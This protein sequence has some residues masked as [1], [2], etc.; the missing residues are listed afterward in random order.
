MPGLFLSHNS[1][2]KRFA[3]QLAAELS[4]NGVRVW[5]DEAEM[6]A[7]DS[8]L[9]KIGEGI[10]RADF[11]GVV[12]SPNSIASRW[13]QKEVEVAATM[14]IEGHGP[15]VIPILYKDCEIPVFL[16]D[17]LYADFRN[18]SM[19]QHSLMKLLDA[20]FPEGFQKRL[21]D[22][23][24]KAIAAEI[25]AYRRLPKIHTR[26]IDRYFTAS[27]SA[28]RRIVNL[29]HERQ[30]RKWVINNRLNPSTHE[31]LEIKLKKIQANVA[32]VETEEYCYL[33]WYGLDAGK[34]QYIYNEKSRQ[35]HTSQT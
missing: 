11:L 21:C 2:D 28:R 19:F 27:G 1:K 9:R 20:V 18:R 25:D 34:Y 32:T 31:L 30:K 6:R 35:T 17:K 14:E 33:R 8:L 22:V 5:I 26:E 23:V 3:R 4:G 24:R 29:L 16:R 15:K 12:L 10:Q 7:G 13:V